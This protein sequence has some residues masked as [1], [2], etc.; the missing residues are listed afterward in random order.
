M[1]TTD[2]NAPQ[3]LAFTGDVF[4]GLSPVKLDPAIS[5]RFRR[6]DHVIANQESPICEPSPIESSKILLRSTPGSERVLKDWGITDVTLAN[7]HIFDHGDNGFNATCKVLA[8][9]E[10]HFAGAGLNEEQAGKPLILKCHTI[11][12]GIIACTEAGTEAKLASAD[13]SGCHSLDL[14][15]IRD[16]IGELKQSVDFVVVTPHWGFCDYKFPPLEV[17]KNGE[18]LLD[19]GADLVIGH[20]SHVVQGFHQ[21]PNGQAVC[22]S[23]GD[24]AFGAYEA[25]GGRKIDSTREGA[26][27]LIVFVELSK[28]QAPR[29]Q[30]EFTAFNGNTVSLAQGQPERKVEFERRSKPLIQLDNYPEYWRRVVRKRLKKRLLY[31]ANPFHIKH[32]R[33]A[34]FNAVFIM[35]G[36]MIRKRVGNNHRTSL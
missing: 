19:A 12:I 5:E 32:L 29:L 34:T 15:T 10:I 4:L 21:R 35:L 17:V 27:G 30:F 25:H 24:F 18:A 8:N 23:L 20:H 6:C 7:N 3:R 9:A 2:H 1:M 13:E 36:E 16:Q 31:W 22:Y 14:P 28:A 33:L 11:S 26:K